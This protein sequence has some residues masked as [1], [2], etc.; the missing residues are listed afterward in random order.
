VTAGIESGARA[1]PAQAPARLFLRNASDRQIAVR[2]TPVRPSPPTKPAET[3]PKRATPA[4]R[5]VPPP[6][7]YDFGF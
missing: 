6:P 5:P 1:E 4:N 3:K 2:T 7:K